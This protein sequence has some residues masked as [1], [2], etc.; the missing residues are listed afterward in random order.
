M[1]ELFPPIHENRHFYLPVNALHEVYV[2]ECG[3]EE[4]VPVVFLHGGPGAGC[5]DYHRQ[6]LILKNI[7]L[8]YLI[9]VVVVV[10]AHTQNYVKIPHRI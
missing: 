3:E 4:G 10:P 6:L 8:F 7:V 5:E 1:S 2:E 9:N